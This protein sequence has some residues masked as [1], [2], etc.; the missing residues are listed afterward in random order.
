MKR[1]I[2]IA[3]IALS[4]RVAEAAFVYRFETSATGIAART[5]TGTVAVD[6]ER[7]RIDFTHGDG[8]VFADG[9][10]AI[11]SQRGGTLDVVDPKRR[12]WFSIPIDA[13]GGGGL[14][15]LRTLVGLTVT[16]PSVSVRDAGPGL[17]IAG[18]A[19]RRRI[20]S[21]AA[22]VATSAAG[23]ALH[24]RIVIRT[25]AWLT[26]AIPAEY[27]SLLQG[28]HTGIAEIDRL[29]DAEPALRRGFPLKEITTTKL[30]E[31]GGSVEIVSTTVV[32]GIANRAVTPAAFQVPGAFTKT[33]SPIEKALEG[34]K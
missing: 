8:V 32:S 12:S 6:G 25:E 31:N 14:D 19:T 34:L 20:S 4:S 18:Y 30:I 27:A 28:V 29:I 11:A 24:V 16:H 5:I 3:A 10:F 21:V 22:D 7:T 9:S 15:Q 23:N 13:L 26:D 2:A 17:P 33:K 1:L